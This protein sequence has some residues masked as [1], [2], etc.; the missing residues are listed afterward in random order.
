MC[1]FELEETSSLTI[2]Q[3]I[4]S[5]RQYLGRIGNQGTGITFINN[6][7]NDSSC[8]NKRKLHLSKKGA[9]ILLKN[10]ADCLKKG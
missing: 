2:F 9:S 6:D 1:S 8:V 3:F 10:F 5:F 4:V 7:N